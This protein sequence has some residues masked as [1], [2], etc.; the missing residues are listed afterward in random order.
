MKETIEVLYVL[1]PCIHDTYICMY[2]YNSIQS[3]KINGQ[4]AKVDINE[5]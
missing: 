4:V 1:P 3:T 2:M 5:V